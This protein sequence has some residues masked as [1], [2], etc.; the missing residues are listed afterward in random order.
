M[1]ILKDKHLIAALVA[2]ATTGKFAGASLA[3]FWP[4]LFPLLNAAVYTFVFSV[5]LRAQPSGEYREVPY[6]VWLLA[7]LA[8]WALMSESLQI[9][10]R[11]ITGNKNMVKKTMFDKRVLPLSCVLSSLPSHVFTLLILICIMLGFGFIP[12]WTTLLLPFYCALLLLFTLGWSYILSALNV[13]VSDIS[14]ILS[15][16]LQL[17]FFTTPIVYPAE[18]V[19]KN[20]QLFVVMNPVHHLIS[21]YREAL[22]LGTLPDLPVI[23]FVLAVVVLFWWLGDLLFR[24]L[25]PTFSDFL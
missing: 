8:P 4:V 17:V 6:S 5:I 19:P 24:A 20:L 10:V 11:A 9:S 25:A 23:L 2:R 1:F 3:A 14:H 16:V 21:F 12:K 7:G 13:F 18:Q 22:L 15:V